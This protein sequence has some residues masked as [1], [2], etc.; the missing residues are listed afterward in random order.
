MDLI[1]FP[2][3]TILYNFGENVKKIYYLV[4]GIVSVKLHNKKLTFE[5]GTFGEWA[6]FDLPS[7]EIVTIESDEATFYQF[8]PEEVLQ[9]ENHDSILR[10]I[11]N[12]L[13]KRLLLIDSELAESRELP[14]YVGPDRMRY[15]KRIHPN[16]MKIDDRIF[17][18]ILNAKRLYSN[19][20]VKEAFDV[21]VRLLSEPV[22]DELRKEIMVWYTL[23]SII[24]QPESAELHLRRL[25]SKEYSDCLSYVYLFSFVHGGQKQDILEIFM[26]GGLLLPPYT[27]V[28]LEGEKANEGYLVLKGY[29]KAVKLYEDKEILLSIVKPGEFVG[30][31]ALLD[32][33]I[34]MVTLY[35]ISPAAIIPISC[36]GIEKY[37]KNNPK[38][39]L[40]IIES[41]L[42][43]IKQV[44]KL[45]SMKFTPNSGQRV[46]MA[47]KYFENIFNEAKITA[48]D[49]SAFIDVP[50]ERVVD[51]LRKNGFKIAAD[52]TISF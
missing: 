5:H 52:G 30:E 15:F 12:S 1:T 7:E 6:F 33:K 46:L 48:K 22:N 14:E 43:R 8:R 19:G 51:E 36:E 28:T 27:V 26:K 23:L 17:Q 41:Q 44:K 25:N 2:R 42:M 31:G 47:I 18:D 3:E 11:I 50:V 40:K 13:S 32:S 9:I 49:I 10:T 39:V 4:E 20:Y 34:R 37:I 16:S 35:S 24:L 38:F 45:I 21:V 29:L